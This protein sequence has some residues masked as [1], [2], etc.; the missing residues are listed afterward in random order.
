MAMSKLKDCEAILLLGQ[1][2]S[3]EICQREERLRQEGSALFYSGNK[4]VNT[5]MKEMLD[6]RDKNA[7]QASLRA[8]LENKGTWQREI[9][10]CYGIS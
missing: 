3:K 9:A 4:L 6:I 8:A 1:P 7:N 2:R 5:G 10:K